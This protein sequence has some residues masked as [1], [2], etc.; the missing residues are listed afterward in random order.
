MAKVILTSVLIASVTNGKS[1]Y[2]KS[3]MANE[4]EL[5]LYLCKPIYKLWLFQTMSSVGS[6]NLNLNKRFTSSG[7]EDMGIHKF[8]FVA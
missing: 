1:I 6:N 3:I 2:G 5:S 7:F 8:E 4:T